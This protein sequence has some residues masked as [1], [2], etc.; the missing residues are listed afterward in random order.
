MKEKISFSE[1]V[2]PYRP[3]LLIRID[4][5]QWFHEVKG[6]YFGENLEPW[7]KEGILGNTEFFKDAK[8]HPYFL[9]FTRKRRYRKLN[10]PKSKSEQVYA[11]G[12][13]SCS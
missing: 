2:W 1:I 9:Q 13:A 7:S 12:I 10:L 11:Q 3:D 5:L 8:M 4:F 6:D